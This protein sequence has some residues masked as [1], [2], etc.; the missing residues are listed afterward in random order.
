MTAYAALDHRFRVVCDHP[1]LATRIAEVLAPLR[2]EPPRQAPPRQAPLDD[3]GT[4]RLRVDRPVPGP[5]ELWFDD[6]LVVRSS[7]PSRP[8]AHLLQHINRAA[9]R[10][11]APNATVLHSAAAIS[12][13]GPVLFPAPMEAGK[14]TLVAGLLL[15]GWPYLTDELVAIDPAT[16]RLR[17][18]P[19][20][21][22]LDRGSWPLFP[23]LRPDIDPAIR[24]LLPAQWQVVPP[25]ATG[26]GVDAGPPGVIVSHRYDPG[27]TTRLA[28]LDP[29]DCLGRLIR[30]CFSF[31]ANAAR[32]LEVLAA[33]IDHT[34]CFEL[35]VGGLTR[36]VDLLDD[37]IGAASIATPAQR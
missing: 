3:G 5:F 14:S 9:N 16:G 23:G 31:D 19:R 15:R 12:A 17:T 37:V 18:F 32:D 30:C 7:R 4:Y 24:H 36:A 28:E 29:V 34:P 25:S 11:T 33:T 1:A 6:D 27:A 8:Y 21:I 26:P 35:T 20:A 2:Q 22:S 13:S 10:R